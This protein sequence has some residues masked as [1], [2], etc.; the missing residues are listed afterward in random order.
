M[1]ITLWIVSFL[2]LFTLAIAPGPTIA[3]KDDHFQALKRFSQVLDMVESYYVQPISRKE[4]IDNSIKG[5][6]EELDPHSTYLTPE[7]YKDMQEQT[8]G[9]FSGIGIEI[10]MEQGRLI[11]VA[12]IEDTPAYKAGLLAGDLILE[13]DGE[14]TQDMT[15]MDAV[16][17][18]RG[19][20]GTTVDLLILHKEANKPIEVPIVRGT[21]PIISVKSQSL[22]D[23][24]MYLRLTGF[25][26]STTKNM[27]EKIRDYQKDHTLKGIVLDLR[28]NPGGLLGQAVSVADT[29]IEDGTIV[30]IQGK[31]SANRKDFY[32]SKNASEVK[33]PV[34]VL[35]NAG[36][37]SASEIVAGALQDHKRALIM[38]ER[39]FGKGSVQTI[40]P[41]TDGSGIKLTT[42]LYYTPNGRSI[43]AKG[44]EPDLR[45]PFLAPTADEDK[46]MRKRFTVREKDLSRHLENGSEPQKVK[47]KDA[48]LSK[49][50][51]EQ[52]NQLRMALELV[53]TLPKLKEIN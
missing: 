1:R 20:K 21:I 14:S 15:L 40:I 52:D 22:E 45:I 49:E 11:V 6:I 5:M 36:S 16:K 37:A 27:R 26:E 35:I 13:I 28:N 42:A 43:Q 53:K 7:D 48:E 4:L 12:P 17:R 46:A 34:V 39:S 24:Y 38:G 47:D 9:K 18:I 25:K 41:M 8:A 51:L 10:S 30:Y 3:A 29:F 44:I 33:V 2:L 19:E 31:D 23:G 50:R 32:A